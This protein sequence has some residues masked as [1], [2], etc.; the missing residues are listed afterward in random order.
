MRS[1]RYV[2]IPLMLFVTSLD[3]VVAGLLAIWNR[4]SVVH[5]DPPAIVPG[6]GMRVVLYGALVIVA[7]YVLRFMRRLP[8]SRS[9]EVAAIALSL[10]YWRVQFYSAPYTHGVR[11]MLRNLWCKR[12]GR[13]RGDSRSALLR[14]EWP[15]CVILGR[16]EST[17]TRND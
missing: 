15:G 14:K 13:S 16:V 8:Q 3:L 12:C 9:S 11:G 10:S 6:Y 5:D 4:W 2:V 17:E 7:A 1:A